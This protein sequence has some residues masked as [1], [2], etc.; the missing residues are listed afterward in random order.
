MPV[1]RLTTPPG[2]SEVASTSASEIAGSGRRCAASTTAVLP[3]ASTGASTETRPSRLESC[4]ARTATTPVGS[5]R[6]K[7][8]YGPATGLVPPTTCANL[9]A[10]PAYQTQRSI[11]ASTCCSAAPAVIPSAAA[12]SSANCSRRPSSISATRYSTCPR[13]YAVAADQPGSALRAATTAS[14]TSL[15]EACAA[16]ASSAPVGGRHRVR[17]PGLRARERAADVELVGLAHAQ[18]RRF[19]DELCPCGGATWR[20]A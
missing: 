15:R 12:T 19:G 2:R 10:Q 8:K 7:L 6:E 3:V 5:G 4:G 16:C 18:A 1:S 17:A 13:L 11:A 20:R 14:R 9:S